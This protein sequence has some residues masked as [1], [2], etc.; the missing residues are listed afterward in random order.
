MTDQIVKIAEIETGK[1]VVKWGRLKSIFGKADLEKCPVLI[2]SIS[3][4]SRGGKSFLLN[5]LWRLLN[6]KHS[7]DNQEPEDEIPHVFSSTHQAEPATV[8]IDIM[9]EPFK[10]CTDNGECAVFLM[11]TQGNEADKESTSQDPHIFALS[12]WLSSYQIINVNRRINWGEVDSIAGYCMHAQT[13]RLDNDQTRQSHSK[14][15]FLV[16]D[17]PKDPIY[18]HGAV[19]GRNY[20]SMKHADASNEMKDLVTI[21]KEVKCFLLPHP[22]LETSENGCR[23]WSGVRELCRVNLTNLKEE[24]FSMNTLRCLANCSL[25][26][27]DMLQLVENLKTQNSLGGAEPTIHGQFESYK[28]IYIERRMERCVELYEKNMEAKEVKNEEILQLEIRDKLAHQIAIAEFEKEKLTITDAYMN[29][30]IK[31]LKTAFEKILA[32]N[33]LVTYEAEWNDTYSKKVAGV[34]KIATTFSQ[35]AIRKT[36]MEIGEKHFNDLKKH[37]S[38]AEVLRLNRDKYLEFLNK[39]YEEKSKK[40]NKN[41]NIALAICGAVAGFVGCAALVA[42]PPLAA[43][44]VA[45]EIPTV[46]V[47]AGGATAMGSAGAAAGSGVGL[48]VS[49]ATDQKIESI[50][51]ADIQT[52]EHDEER[53][54]SA[55]EEAQ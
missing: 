26:G 32:K 2:Y 54:C 16:R 18:P 36:F 41:K 37:I 42:I 12:A 19:G 39:V 33:L 9:K 53:L 21:Y 28:Q 17:W 11:D 45:V 13:S 20:F 30:F 24:L 8:G 23:Q 46:L 5:T 47:M 44:A 25:T 48:G 22:G 29:E 7:Q 15:L 6:S 4:K 51:E 40:A 1:V 38:D 49:K 3:G 50:S 34:K 10:I 35:E 27:S 52:T 31:R 14:L 55:Q 43:I